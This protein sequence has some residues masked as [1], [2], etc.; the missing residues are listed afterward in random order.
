M[1]CSSRYVSIV[2]FKH[3]PFK[4][5]EYDDDQRENNRAILG[6]GS[7]DGEE[8]EQEKEDEEG[9]SI[10]AGNDMDGLSFKQKFPFDETRS[11]FDLFGNEPCDNVCFSLARK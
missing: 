8:D 11:Y 10:T 1:E 7:K 2:I 3:L 4:L 5:L 9:A 6:R